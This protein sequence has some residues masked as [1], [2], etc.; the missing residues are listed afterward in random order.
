MTSATVEGPLACSPGPT[1]GS[2][3]AFVALLWRDVF[4]TGTEAVAFLA[5]VLLQPVFLLFVFGK[6]LGD[7]GYTRGNFAGVLFP[8]VVAFTAFLTALQNT[9]VPAGNRLLLHQG[10]R[11]PPARAAAHGDGGGREDRLRH[12]AVACRRRADVP[13]GALDPRA[14]RRCPGRTRP[15]SAVFL[16]LGSLVGAASA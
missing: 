2:G 9:G 1:G 12:A 8:G 6:V 3:R 11:G 16:L 15:W 14:A 4:V 10:D 5:Q 7:L 13:A